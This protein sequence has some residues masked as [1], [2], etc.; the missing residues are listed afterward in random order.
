MQEVAEALA[1]GDLTKSSGLT[2]KDELGRMGA[3]L[4]T[5]VTA[6]VT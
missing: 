6:F 4:D 1:A 3:A 2:T 5:A